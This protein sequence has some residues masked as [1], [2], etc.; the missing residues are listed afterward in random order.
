MAPGLAYRS[1]LRPGCAALCPGYDGD[2][3]EV[4]MRTSVRQRAMA[5]LAAVL[6]ATSWGA[7]VQTQFNL[8]EL[9]ALGADVPLELRL[10]T[11]V[12]DLIGFGPL[13]A[14]VV[15]LA[16]GLALPM[17]ALVARRAPSWRGALFV[18]AGWVGLI[19]AIRIVDALTPPPVLIAA[20]R[21]TLGLL[22]MTLGGAFGGWLVGWMTRPTLPPP[23]LDR[24]RTGQACP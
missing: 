8:Q 5:F 18:L 15:V 22:A 16:L 24:L 23:S 3:A 7:V 14:V 1:E 6:T 10:L 2:T 4:E 17:A 13:Y 9:Q 12:Q 11:T 20:T 21:S 19:V